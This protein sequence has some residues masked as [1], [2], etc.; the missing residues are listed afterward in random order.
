MLNYTNPAMHRGCIRN[1]YPIPPQKVLL[2]LPEGRRVRRVELLH[3][4]KDI[5]FR[6]N[7]GMLEFTVPA[8]LSYE[9]AAVS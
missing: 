5:P 2:E 6:V 1:F 7:S 8:V 4:E 3:A 9:V